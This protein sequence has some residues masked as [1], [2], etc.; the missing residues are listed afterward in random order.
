MII[1]V[2]VVERFAYYGISAN[3]ITYLTGPLGQSTAIAAENVNVW[4]GTTW[5][6]PLLGAFLA[7]SL[8]GRYHTIVIASLIYILVCVVCFACFTSSFSIC[9]KN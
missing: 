4:F 3:L 7:D 2:E 6:L 8:L 5:L 1:G 9:H